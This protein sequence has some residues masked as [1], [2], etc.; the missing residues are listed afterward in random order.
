M[1]VLSMDGCVYVCVYVCVFMFVCVCMC[2][3]MLVPHGHALMYRHPCI[4]TAIMLVYWK[5]KVFIGN[6]GFSLTIMGFH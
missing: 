1:H 5:L 4:L 2:V 6:Y 3:S